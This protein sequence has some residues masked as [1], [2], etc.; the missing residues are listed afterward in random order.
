MIAACISLTGCPSISISTSFS[1]EGAPY[2]V[3][4]VAP[5]HQEAK[6]LSFAKTIEEAINISNMI[7]TNVA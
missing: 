5:P 7:P 3:Q 4:I 2:G 1:K 6:L